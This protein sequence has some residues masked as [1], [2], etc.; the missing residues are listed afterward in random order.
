MQNIENYQSN[1]CSLDPTESWYVSDVTKDYSCICPEGQSQVSKLL[2]GEKIYKCQL[3]EDNTNPDVLI[4][5]VDASSSRN[6]TNPNN[7]NNSNNPLTRNN[8]NRQNN[9]FNPIIKNTQITQPQPNPNAYLNMNN[10]NPSFNTEI[11]NE[12]PY[13][14]KPSNW[15]GL[16]TDSTCNCP[17]PLTQVKTDINNNTYFTCSWPSNQ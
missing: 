17:H 6:L 9:I 14:N 16:S 15:V 12:T 3:D 2:G 10:P 7:P 11:C 8:S 5:S 13:S 4:N 1:L